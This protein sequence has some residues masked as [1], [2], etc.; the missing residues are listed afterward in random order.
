[1]C[2]PGTSHQGLDVDP[3]GPSSDIF[4]AING[5]PKRSEK[6]KYD[7]KTK[8]LVKGIAKNLLR[9]P[10]DDESMN[11]T[12]LSSVKSLNR[13]LTGK[14]FHNRRSPSSSQEGIYFEKQKDLHLQ[15]IYKCTFRSIRS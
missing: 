14:D 8:K 2:E 15:K 1:M 9:L 7:S 13:A 5:I 12:A 6:D 3:S 4:Q 10:S 11:S